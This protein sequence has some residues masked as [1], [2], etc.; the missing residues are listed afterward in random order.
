MPLRKE[1]PMKKKNQKGLSKYEIITEFEAWYQSEAE[2]VN[3]DNQPIIITPSDEDS[4][5]DV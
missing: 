1:F 2:K 3:E 5:D 4:I